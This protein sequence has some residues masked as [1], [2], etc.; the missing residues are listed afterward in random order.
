[1]LIWFLDLHIPKSCDNFKNVEFFFLGWSCSFPIIIH[2]N[3]ICWNKKTFSDSSL[4]EIH[5]LLRYNCQLWYLSFFLNRTS[6]Q[7]L[8]TPDSGF[9]KQKY[10]IYRLNSAN[11]VF[12]DSGEISQMKPKSHKKAMP[13]LSSISN[14]I[15]YVF[16]FHFYCKLCYGHFILIAN[17]RSEIFS[18]AFSQQRTMNTM[19]KYLIF[20]N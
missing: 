20:E 3:Y 15:I 7:I 17:I 2:E 12:C 6:L 18:T 16:P 4:P 13:P 10:V 8:P 1:M 14:V 11:V 5:S 19:S 9:E